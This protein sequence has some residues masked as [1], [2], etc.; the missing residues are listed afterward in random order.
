MNHPW[1]FLF[2]GVGGAA[3]LA[4]L[5]W[6]IRTVRSRKDGIP[7]SIVPGTVDISSAESSVAVNNRS[8]SHNSPVVLGSHNTIHISHPALETEA[9]G[10]AGVLRDASEKEHSKFSVE[11][12][13]AVFLGIPLLFCFIGGLIW[14]LLHPGTVQ[15]FLQGNRAA[16]TISFQYGNGI[17]P[18]EMSH[19]GDQDTSCSEVGIS[20]LGEGSLSSTPI[21][22]PGEYG[23]NWSR[24]AVI[25]NYQED[26]D[27]SRI[28]I[29]TTGNDV[30]LNYA[31]HRDGITYRQIEFKMEDVKSILGSQ[32]SYWFPVDIM[33][34]DTS[35]P[36]P[37]TVTV[38]E[39]H[40]RAHLATAYFVI[41]RKE[42]AHLDVPGSKAR[43]RALGTVTGSRRISVSERVTA[44]IAEMTGID[45]SQIRPNDDLEINLGKTPTEVSLLFD[46]LEVEFGIT[47]PKTDALKI[48]TVG[49]VIAYIEV[50]AGHK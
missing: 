8:S 39:D 41:P 48:R 5:G 31:N 24:I 49:E 1:E 19:T 12:A 27:V 42:P 21:S 34:H 3:V 30:S 26:G 25:V 14:A 47:I 32:R 35:T 11:D 33:V 20:C 6:V 36:F 45:R 43:S 50:K 2:D 15:G 10:D 38:E 18:K 9:L 37:I 17:T 22:I 28:L 23:E 4:L 13:L 7:Q 29:S 46:E 16:A 44:I 40:R